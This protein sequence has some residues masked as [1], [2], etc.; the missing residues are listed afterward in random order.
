MSGKINF[1]KILDEKRPLVYQEIKKYLDQLLDFPEYCQIP[2]KYSVLAKFHYQITGD[3]CFRQ[4][5]YVRPSLVLLTGSAMGYPEEKAV[6]TAAAM[7]IS[8]NWILNHDDIEDD[9]LKRRG[10]PCLH[11]QIGTELAINAG[12]AL[13]ILMWKVLGDNQEI[14]GREKA[15]QIYNEFCVMLARTAL[16]QTLDIGW[17]KKNK[18][19]LE[20]EDVLFI[21]E[22]K[23]G[24]YS[25]AGP[26]R[27]GA[28]LAGADENQL[29]QLYQFGK[30][31]GYCYQIQDDLLDLTSNF[32]GRK[33]IQGNDIYESKITV[34]LI[35]LLNNISQKEK[36][37]LTKIINKKREN[38]SKGEVDWVIKRME[39]NGSLTYGR[40]L[41]KKY[42][43]QSDQFFEKK[44]SFLKHQPA[45][46]QIKS[47]ID[48]LKTRRY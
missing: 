2:E 36:P 19:D 8:E 6:R 29:K 42:A 43:N 33:Q 22:S 44:L 25:I 38:K 18:F 1:L 45:R 28:I 32:K 20:V 15:N 34:M 26:M 48:F 35:H 16:G 30:L 24:Y 27:L 12:D 21:A 10:K 41:V 11:R 23:T 31:T 4:G 46:N 3:Y 40:N 7:E 37:K 9:S 14:I 13:H 39:K 5:K 17:I 47:F